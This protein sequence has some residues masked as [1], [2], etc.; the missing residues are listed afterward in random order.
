[1]DSKTNYDLIIAVVNKRL[2][3]QVSD[4]IEHLGMS[5]I[6]ILQGRG[7]ST[8]RR[9]EFIGIV[10]EPQREAIMVLL[11]NDKTDIVYDTIMEAGKLDEP[12]NGVV[13]VLDVKRLGGLGLNITDE[14][15]F[16]TQ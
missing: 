10:V 15:N 4:A 2:T 14:D 8:K 6:T 7:R 3:L 9:V 12:G 11:P 1:M 5:G 13:F 16:G